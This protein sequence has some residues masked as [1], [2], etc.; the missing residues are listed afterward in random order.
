M[1][2]LQ[3]LGMPSYLTP[4]GLGDHGKPGLSYWEEVP[5]PVSFLLGNLERAPY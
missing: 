4:G 1:N 3:L 5:N 2:C